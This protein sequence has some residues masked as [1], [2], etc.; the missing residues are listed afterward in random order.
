MLALTPEEDK[1]NAQAGSL[2]GVRVRQRSDDV[3]GSWWVFVTHARRRLARSFGPGKAAK[4]LAE[5]EA[6]QLR[7][8]IARGQAEEIFRRKTAAPALPAPSFAVL[9]SDA[10]AHYAG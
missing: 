8:Q 6:I 10:L 2:M 9:A 7:A 3:T 5:R 1:A 4:A